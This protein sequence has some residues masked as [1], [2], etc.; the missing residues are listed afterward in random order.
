MTIENVAAR[1]VSLGRRVNNRLG[2]MIRR[3]SVALK[4][5][6][7][8]PETVRHQLLR[9]TTWTLKERPTWDRETWQWVVDQIAPDTERFLQFYG[10][11]TDYWRFDYKCER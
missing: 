6:R 4:I 5:G 1:N 2:A 7:M 3:S 8:L 10:K 9:A 11:P